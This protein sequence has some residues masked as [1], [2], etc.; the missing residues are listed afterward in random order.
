MYIEHVLEVRVD[1]S[2]LRFT[3]KSI[4][5]I[6]DAFS[7]KKPM[8]IPY[9]PVPDW[10]KQNP[11][12]V[13]EPGNSLPLEK[14]SKK[15][16]WRPAPQ[17]VIDIALQE[18]FVAMEVN[19]EGNDNG[20]FN[21]GTEGG[22]GA[23]GIADEVVTEVDE[24]AHGRQHG[25]DKALAIAQCM[26]EEKTQEY[27]ADVVAYKAR[28]SYLESRL[29]AFGI[30]VDGSSRNALFLEVEEFDRAPPMVHAS[31]QAEKDV[32][33]EEARVVNL[34]LELS[35][36]NQ[37]L[38]NELEVLRQNPFEAENQALQPEAEGLHH[39]LHEA[40]QHLVDYNSTKDSMQKL[41]E[42]NTKLNEYF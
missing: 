4:G 26:L 32:V 11:K 12:L 31:V 14:I 23:D 13:D 40:N 17:N 25:S 33:V 9:S 36:V 39:Q 18:I 2:T 35:T 42:E 15:P 38:Q 28:I 22:A 16:K 1:W 24:R 37:E 30:R 20:Q 21:K 27:L 19:V 3:N 10:F 29:A 5:R 7:K 6:E 41:Q 34:L 8:E